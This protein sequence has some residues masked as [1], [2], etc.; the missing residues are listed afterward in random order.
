MLQRKLRIAHI[1]DEPE[2]LKLLER[3]INKYLPDAEYYVSASNLSDGKQLVE[4]SPFDLLFLD[5]QLL[6]GDGM[7]LVKEYP[8]IAKKTILCTAD[9]TKGIEAIKSGIFYYV[10]KPINIHEIIEIVNKYTEQITEETTIENS[11]NLFDNKLIVR[12]NNGAEIIPIDTILRFESEVNYTTI[13]LVDGSKLLV[14]KTLKVFEDSL[15]S[16]SFIRIHR[17]HL[18]NANYIRRV[19]KS[20]GG[21]IELTTGEVFK[22]SQTGR[23]KIKEKLNI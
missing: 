17:S 12:D 4:Q 13:F 15:I 14:S 3:I 7:S 18:I 2:A 11:L 9:D 21:S 22:L 8:E 10:L 5:L 1:E 16:F 19:N 20:D 23:E 6:D